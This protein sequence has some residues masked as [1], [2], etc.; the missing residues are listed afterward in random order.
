MSL[1]DIEKTLWFFTGI[2]WLVAAFN[3]KKSVT[4]QNDLQ[5]II[6]MCFWVIAFLLLFT[7]NISFSFLY[8]SFFLQQPAFKITGMIL[9]IS[10]LLFAV[11]ARIYLGKNWSGRIAIKQEHELIQTGPY[12]LTR[13]P[14][15]TGFLLAFIGCAM[16]EGLLKGYF[17]LLF[18]TAGIFLKIGKEE[19]YMNQVFADSYVAYKQRVKKLLPFIY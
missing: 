7:N 11:W 6:Y 12:A 15:Y 19:D 4:R 3:V 14:I 8:R 1:I 2:Y 9:C 16:T 17:S 5:R 18:I 10:G 13:N